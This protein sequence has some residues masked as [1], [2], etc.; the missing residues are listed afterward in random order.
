MNKRKEVAKQAMQ[1]KKNIIE[2]THAEKE[3]VD[4]EQVDKY[5]F[6]KGDKSPSLEKK[7]KE[8]TGQGNEREEGQHTPFILKRHDME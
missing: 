5:Q 1:K 8:L 6:K 3:C 7:I 2:N 4:K